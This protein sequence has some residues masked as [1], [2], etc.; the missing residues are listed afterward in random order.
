MNIMPV[1]D[2]VILVFGAYMV[3]S[4]M[5]MKKTGKINTTVIT[6]EEIKSGSDQ[7]G[8]IGYIYRK[9]ALFG[10]IIIIV[11]ILGLVND[12][13]ISLGYF[14]ILEMILFLAAFLWFQH[15]LGKARAQF[16]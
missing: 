12:L 4:A 7:A 10:G 6:A 14:N 5:K 3:L 1:I 13:L 8:F 16:L 2:L 15:H 11:G 9:E